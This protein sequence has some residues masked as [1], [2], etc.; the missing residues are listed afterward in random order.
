MIGF[1]LWL[2]VTA[3]GVLWRARRS[4]RLAATGPYASVRHPQY[5]GFLLVMVG[6]LLQWPTIPTLLMFPILVWVYR[7]L[8]LLEERGVWPGFGAAW[9]VYAERTPRFVP[10]IHS[11][12]AP[13]GARHAPSESG[14]LH[15]AETEERA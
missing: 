9:D 6:F 13:G 15:D 5:V 14:G 12:S 8:S 11:P 10:R 1:G 2:I 4:E 7:R 3:W